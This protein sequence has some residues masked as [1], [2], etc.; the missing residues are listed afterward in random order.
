MRLTFAAEATVWSGPAFAV[1]R[2]LPAAETLTVVFTVRLPP[3]P[4]HIREYV[5]FAVN[6]PVDC[7]PD[8]AFAP[9]QPF[10]AVQLVAFVEDQVSIELEPE[11]TEVGFAVSVTVGI[12]AVDD[13]ST[14]TAP[15]PVCPFVAVQVREKR[16]AAESA[17]VLPVPA[18][19]FEP[20]HPPEATQVAALV[21]DQVIV[22]EPP[23]VTLVGFA[24]TVTVGTTTSGGASLSLVC[25]SDPHA[26]MKTRGATSKAAPTT[27]RK[28]E[29]C[30]RSIPRTLKS[31]HAEL[32]KLRTSHER[33]RF[34]V[35]NQAVRFSCPTH[36]ISIC[37]DD[38]TSKTSGDVG[39]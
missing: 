1:G 29:K 7:V 19:A 37:R 39:G 22:E 24:E 18:V 33:L 2:A 13:T 25:A 11:V 26:E 3:A 27:R 28:V 5:V 31:K 12:G 8:V 34:F 23:A 21:E 16:V 14:V 30:I 4:V 17:P 10:E 15:Y 6:V 38:Q 9:V 20:V 36:R 35:L 32:S